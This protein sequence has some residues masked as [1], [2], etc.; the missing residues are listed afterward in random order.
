MVASSLT[1]SVLFASSWDQ[2][3]KLGQKTKNG[4]F[5]R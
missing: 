2:L 1:A 5:A 3:Q 4:T